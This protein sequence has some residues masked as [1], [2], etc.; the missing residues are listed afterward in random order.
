MELWQDELPTLFDFEPLTTL[1][2]S[3]DYIRF[4]VRALTGHPV[5]RPFMLKWYNENIYLKSENA[6]SPHANGKR[7]LA[8]LLGIA[9]P[10]RFCPYC[11]NKAEAEHGWQRGT[12]KRHKSGGHCNV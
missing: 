1:R 11:G 3:M 8:V 2:E 7:P 9:P 4:S 5:S 10:M 6:P 12:L